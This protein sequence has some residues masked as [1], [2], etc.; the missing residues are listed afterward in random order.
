MVMSRFL[1]GLL[2]LAFVPEGGPLLVRI[3]ETWERRQGKKIGSTGWFRDAGR[4]TAT[5]VA[6][7]LGIR[8]CCLGL[9]VAVP[10]SRRPWAFPFL[11]VPVLS[12]KTATRRGKPPRSG[13]SW[14]A[15][16]ACKLRAWSPDR[17]I[18]L[19]GDGE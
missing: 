16:L 6:V 14:A 9:L 10:W 1:L 2:V 19:V 17:E 15:C 4:S 18:I 12:E 13:V 7:A 11:V 5:K 3:D 8:W